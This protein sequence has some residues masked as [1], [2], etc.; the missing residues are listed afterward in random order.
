MNIDRL[1]DFAYLALRVVAGFMYFQVGSAILFGWF[2]GMHYPEG[3]SAPPLLSQMGV[4]AVLEFVGGL[5]VLL[6]LFTRPAAFIV[7]GEMAVGYWQ[8]HAPNGGWPFQNGGVAAVLYCFVFLYLAARGG[9]EW[10]LDA[11]FRTRREA[12]TSNQLA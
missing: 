9:G 4:G 1:M 12:R 8:F 3:M 6:G 10:S 7:A 11:W 2:G 5:L